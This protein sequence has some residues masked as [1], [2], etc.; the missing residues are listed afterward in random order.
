[1]RCRMSMLNGSG[2]GCAVMER[3]GVCAREVLIGGGGLRFG[4]LWMFVGG[5]YGEEVTFGDSQ[6]GVCVDV[7]GEIVCVCLCL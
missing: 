7:E 1:M 3:L 5:F 4:I 2:L 6:R